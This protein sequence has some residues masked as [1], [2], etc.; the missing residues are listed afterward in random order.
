MVLAKSYKI[1][2]ASF[3]QLVISIIY[4]NISPLKKA[5][6]TASSKIS[7]HFTNSIYSLCP[8]FVL[9]GIKVS[10]FVGFG[11]FRTVT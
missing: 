6:P 7:P 3:A 11:D 9:L 2:P 1:L 8:C 10:R 4:S 5:A